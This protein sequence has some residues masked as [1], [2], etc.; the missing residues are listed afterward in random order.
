MNP[1]P[2]VAYKQLY[3]PEPGRK[4]VHAYV[5]NHTHFS[6]QLR[7][8][9]QGGYMWYLDNDTTWQSKTPP[10]VKHTGK[11]MTQL[12]TYDGT[13][14]QFNFMIDRASAKFQPKQQLLHFVYKRSWEDDYSNLTVI[15][16]RETAA[17]GGS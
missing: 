17:T 10:F 2:V 8:N 5:S 11:T 12:G 15:L 14:Q 1:I 3:S 13:I 7:A 6:I 16:Q 4:T 9:P